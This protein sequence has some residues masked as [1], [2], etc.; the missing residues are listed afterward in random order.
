MP[1]DRT[2]QL[3]ALYSLGGLWASDTIRTIDRRFKEFFV[4][5]GNDVFGVCPKWDKLLVKGGGCT[6]AIWG[7]GQ[8]VFVDGSP[9][10]GTATFYGITGNDSWRRLTVEFAITLIGN[11]LVVWSASLER[12][13]RL[14]FE[15]CADL[16]GLVR[17]ASDEL[18]RLVNARLGMLRSAI[19]IQ[20]LFAQTL[21]VAG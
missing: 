10:T 14:Q 20:D 19:E 13:D 17:A 9:T 6:R 12:I 18:R 7:R 5:Q 15:S 3:N 1:A 8:F 16:D 21:L 4:P 11:N 2:G